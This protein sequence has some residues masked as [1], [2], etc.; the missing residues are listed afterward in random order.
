MGSKNALKKLNKLQKK[1]KK[2][3]NKSLKQLSAL[4][5]NPGNDDSIAGSHSQLHQEAGQL[6]EQ[7]IGSMVSELTQPLNP[8]VSKLNHG[9]H[10]MINKPQFD[11]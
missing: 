11:Q 6:A 3:T 8:V 4:A 7:V 9:T 5:V 2:L 10:K 1:S